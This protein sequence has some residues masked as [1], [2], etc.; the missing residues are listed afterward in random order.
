V[1]AASTRTRTQDRLGYISAIS[2]L[3]LGV[4]SY[5]HAGWSHRLHT[6]TVRAHR[7]VTQATHRLHTGYTQAPYS[8]TSAKKSGSFPMRSP[9]ELMPKVTHLPPSLM[10]RGEPESPAQLALSL[11]GWWVQMYPS[12]AQSSALRHCAAERSGRS[13]SRRWSGYLR[14]FCS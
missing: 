1:R 2:R 3:Y 11:S 4:D 7:V 6:G 12:S 13:T 5:A 8:T 9:N 10:K 14:M